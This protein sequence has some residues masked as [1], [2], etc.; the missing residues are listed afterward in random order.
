M[1]SNKN[2]LIIKVIKSHQEFLKKFTGKIS[3]QTIDN[4][5]EYSTKINIPVS[6]GNQFKFSKSGNI[7]FKS[8][9][10]FSKD[11]KNCSFPVREESTFCDANWAFSITESLAGIKCVK[12]KK[13]TALSAQQLIDC[14]SSY[15]NEGC[16]NGYFDA[17]KY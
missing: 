17:C 6:V 2:F 1:D 5:S 3:P 16:S 12:T 9:N 15:G 8:I 4:V 14:S 10:F 7:S 11:W 13:L